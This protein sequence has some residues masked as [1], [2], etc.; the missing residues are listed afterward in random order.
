M[1]FANSNTAHIYNGYGYE[2]NGDLISSFGGQNPGFSDAW[3]NRA[4][5]GTPNNIDRTNDAMGGIPRDFW[6][7]TE[8][9][10]PLNMDYSG[11][12]MFGG[13]LRYML[14]SDFGVF[15]ELNGTF[16]VTVGQFTIERT[17]L[18]L[19]NQRDR[20]ETFQIRGE[21]QRLSVNI[22]IHQVIGRKAAE[23]KGKTPTIL[24]F[25]DV[26]ATVLFSKFEESFIQLNGDA[27]NSEF[28][29]DLTRFYNRQGAQTNEANLLTGVGLGG[30]ANG[31]IQITLGRKF[32]IDLCYVANLQQVRLGDLSEVGFQHQVL[33]RAIYM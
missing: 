23:R 15:A 11:S 32:T 8:E 30:F 10:M 12:F 4:I 13:H 5:Q 22:G 17:D 19:G 1:Y 27:P 20:I 14:N 24:P 3:L 7:F 26:G 16:P 28:E 31:G 33:L 25:I 29:V 2:R 6:A 21:E 18:P 9:D